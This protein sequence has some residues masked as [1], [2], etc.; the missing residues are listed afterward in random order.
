MW[1]DHYVSFAVS[2]TIADAFSQIGL[3][4]WIR[5][6]GAVGEAYLLIWAAARK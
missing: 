5:R 2:Q 3:E 6:V 1:V 4:N